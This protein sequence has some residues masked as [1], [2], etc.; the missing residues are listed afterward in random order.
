MLPLLQKFGLM[1]RDPR[2]GFL[3]DFLRCFALD[4]CNGFQTDLHIQA[5]AS[6]VHMRRQMVSLPQLDTVFIAKSIFGRHA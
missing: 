6:E 5:T 2:Q 4:N 1:G 3:Q